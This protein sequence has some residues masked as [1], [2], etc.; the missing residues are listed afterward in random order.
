VGVGIGVS[1]LPALLL[2]LTSPFRLLVLGLFLALAAGAA[3]A[4]LR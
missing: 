2:A 3:I 4:R 1:S